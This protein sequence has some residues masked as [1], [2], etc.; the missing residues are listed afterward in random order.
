ML[1]IIWLFAPIFPPFI[2]ATF[3]CWLLLGQTVLNLLARTKPFLHTPQLETN[4]QTDHLPAHYKV[5][6]SRKARVH[7]LGVWFVT[8]SKSSVQAF[9]SNNIV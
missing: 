4:S 6:F 5:T 8:T 3:F 1:V 9:A 7:F 2:I